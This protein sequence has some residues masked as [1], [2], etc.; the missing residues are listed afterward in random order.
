MKR[1]EKANKVGSC[2]NWAELFVQH[3]LTF[4]KVFEEKNFF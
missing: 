4:N 1:N 2:E 3:F